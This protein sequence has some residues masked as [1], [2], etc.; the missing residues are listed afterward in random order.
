MLHNHWY[1]CSSIVSLGLDW[2]QIDNHIKL[3]TVFYKMHEE[4]K[5][6]NQIQNITYLF[7]G[8]VAILGCFGGKNTVTTLAY[9]KT[10]EK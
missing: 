10:W 4:H 3:M 1:S 8:P 9:W 7:R 2:V 5:G 6:H